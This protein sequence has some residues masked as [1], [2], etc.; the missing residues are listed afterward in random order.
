MFVRQS[1]YRAHWMAHLARIW[2]FVTCVPLIKFK[3]TTEHTY[4]LKSGWLCI[5]SR[6][7]YY[8]P[9]MLLQFCCW[10]STYSS[11]Y[12]VGARTGRTMARQYYEMT[13]HY[14]MLCLVLLLLPDYQLNSSGRLT[15][16][17]QSNC[18]PQSSTALIACLWWRRDQPLQIQQ[19]TSALEGGRR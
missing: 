17:P 13:G 1:Q 2:S 19:H 18:T 5:T 4:I 10:W 16:I 15:T 8:S 14:N 6:L 12:T 3:R 7:A 9:I 11:V